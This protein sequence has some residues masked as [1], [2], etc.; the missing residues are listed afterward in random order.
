MLGFV[1]DLRYSHGRTPRAFDRIP[2]TL[3][4]P[5]NRAVFDDL[6]SATLDGKRFELFEAKLTQ[7]GKNSEQI[8][9]QGAIL[10]CRRAQAFNGLLVATRRTG[11][12]RRFLR[13]LFG[14]GGLEEITVT[15]RGLGALYEFRT[16]NR[17]AARELLAGGAAD[18]LVSICEMWRTETPQVAFC[19]EDV[20]ILLPSTRNFFELPAI[21]RGVSYNGHIE[22]MA[23]QFA[24][25]LAIV[26]A[27]GK[28]DGAGEA[29]AAPQSA[30][31]APATAPQED[32]TPAGPPS[33]PPEETFIPLL[34]SVPPPTE[35][36]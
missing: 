23:R 32:T 15:H 5:H 27:V 31:A 11:E 30:T 19:N 4:P 13:D 16:D 1:P 33:Q 35:I 18:L 3:M 6:I 25:F 22:P 21:D 24:S 20:F 26:R 8:V 14:S 9:F 34:D 17:R 12:F 7:R 29:A 28:L 2:K 10:H 36:K